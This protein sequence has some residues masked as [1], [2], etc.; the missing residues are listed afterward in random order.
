MGIRRRADR[1]RDPERP[2]G[3]SSPRRQAIRDP[4]LPRGGRLLV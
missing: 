4:F 2:G 1:G 3:E